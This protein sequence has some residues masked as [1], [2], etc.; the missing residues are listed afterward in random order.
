[1]LSGREPTDRRLDAN[2][3]NVGDDP[4]HWYP[5]LTRSPWPGPEPEDQIICLEAAE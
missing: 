1:V 2:R 4:A 5:L 3:K